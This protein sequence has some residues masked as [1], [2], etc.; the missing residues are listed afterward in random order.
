MSELTPGPFSG[1]HRRIPRIGLVH[2]V[3]SRDDNRFAHRV[4]AELSG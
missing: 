3:D 2:T 1:R 4:H